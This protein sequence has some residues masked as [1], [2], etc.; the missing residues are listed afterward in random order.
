MS[1]PDVRGESDAES[2]YGGDEVGDGVCDCVVC[3]VDWT[4][5]FGEMLKFEGSDGTNDSIGLLEVRCKLRTV[6]GMLRRR[7]GRRRLL[8]SVHS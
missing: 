5:S 8:C 7:H 4:V 6:V 2:E 1:D 3:G